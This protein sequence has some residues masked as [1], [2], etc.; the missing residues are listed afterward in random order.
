MAPGTG[1][2]QHQS[3][4]SCTMNPESLGD[5]SWAQKRDTGALGAQ[6][7]KMQRKQNK[8]HLLAGKRRLGSVPVFKKRHLGWVR[9]AQAA[10]HGGAHL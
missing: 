1:R 4:L 3:W 8:T 9:K 10:L 2:L 7:S 6:K 5:V